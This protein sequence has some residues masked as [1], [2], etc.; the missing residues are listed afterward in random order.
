MNQKTKQTLLTLFEQV[1]GLKKVWL[2]GS[3]ARGSAKKFS[4]IDVLI[5]AEDTWSARLQLTQLH[6]DSTIPNRLD[7]ITTADL[8]DNFGKEVEKDKILLWESNN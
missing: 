8:I 6:E 7:I 1:I 2:Y 4:D 3:W 5:E